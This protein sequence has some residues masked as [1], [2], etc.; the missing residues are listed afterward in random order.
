MID[1]ELLEILKFISFFI[2]ALV[3]AGIVDAS[4]D[5]GGIIQATVERMKYLAAGIEI[6]PDDPP[7]P[8]S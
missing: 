1:P 6:P 7:W 3:A 8:R 2:G 4:G 5:A